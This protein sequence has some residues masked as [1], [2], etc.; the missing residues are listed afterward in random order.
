MD[1]KPI[2]IESVSAYAEQDF[3]VV[4]LS[5]VKALCVLGTVILHFIIITNAVLAARTVLFSRD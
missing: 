5:V 1:P 4:P 3:A 2:T